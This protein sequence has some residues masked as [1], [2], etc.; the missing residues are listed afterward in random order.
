MW[1]VL[2]HWKSSCSIRNDN[3]HVHSTEFHIEYFCLGYN[4]LK[5]AISIWT[6]LHRKQMNSIVC[7]LVKW[8]RQSNDPTIIMNAVLK[9]NSNSTLR[10]IKRIQNIRIT[11]HVNI[12]IRHYKPI[13]PNLSV[14]VLFLLI[15]PFLFF[16]LLKPNI[17]RGYSNAY[18]CTMVN[19]KMGKQTFT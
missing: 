15:L 13:L 2:L 14:T 3:E 16:V 18:R 10:K 11:Y 4:R 9:C 6:I 8:M 19:K 17:I 12:V 7:Y 1:I 5:L